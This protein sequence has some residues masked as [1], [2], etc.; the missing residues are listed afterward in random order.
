M[1]LTKHCQSIL[2]GLPANR[3]LAVDVLRG[4]TIAAMI[5]VNNPGSWQHVYAPLL[6]AEWHGWTPTDLIFPFFVFIVGVA[7]QMSVNQQRRLGKSD[8]SILLKALIRAIKLI[9]LGLFLALFYYN[10]SDPGYDW[11]SQRLENIRLPGVLQRI[12]IVYFITV[13]I[14]LK[15]QMLSRVFWCMGLLLGYWALFLILPYAD[16]AGNTYAGLMEHGN[17]I[18]AWFD[19]LIL[20]KNHVYYPDAQPFPFDPEGLLSTLPAIATC[21]SGVLAGHW[22]NS[23]KSMHLKALGLLTFGALATVVGLIWDANFPINKALWS[24]SYVMLSSGMACISLSVCLYLIDIF[25]IRNWA[26]PFVVFGA[27]SIA[28]YMFA[29]IVARILIMVSVGEQSAKGWLFESLY[30]PLFG[31]LNGSLAFAVSFL[32]LSYAVMLLMYRKGWFWKV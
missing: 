27:N 18:S 12:G 22:L 5:L 32:I 21:L 24:S 10:F 4:I 8:N 20:G 19:N 7:T 6:H 15:C 9:G 26:A 3:I 23:E 13:L 31:N 28:F 16:S 2:N 29:A 30:S 11:F 1:F 14:V 17:N 25:R